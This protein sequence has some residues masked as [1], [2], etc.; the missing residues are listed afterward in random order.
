[1][2]R[3]AILAFSAMLAGCSGSG[4]SGDAGNRS[5]ETPVA[6][7]PEV[8]SDRPMAWSYGGT[9]AAPTALYGA[10]QGQ[11]TLALTCDREGQL[12]RLRYATASAAPDT[13]LVI[14]VGGQERLIEAEPVP[15]GLEGELLLADPLLGGLGEPASRFLIAAGSEPAL[16]VPGGPAI[17]RTLNACRRPEEVRLT[18]AV[19]AGLLPCADC[20]GVEAVLTFEGPEPGSG[21]YRFSRD[22]RDGRPPVVES[23]TATI[24]GRFGPGV[25][26][27][28]P[29][30]GGQPTLLDQANAGLLLRDADGNPDPV[31]DR[32]PL[33]RRR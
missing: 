11:P 18:G 28:D 15:G 23:G 22:Y 4:E 6:D 33:T 19:F 1:M 20:P 29:E 3:L 24:D 12:M 13:R 31:L 7:R 14:A 27:L 32:F 25:V 16:S 5:A 8:T 17:R 2:M 26:R 10:A 30:G 9:S 21:R